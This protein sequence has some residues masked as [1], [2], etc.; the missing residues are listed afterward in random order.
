MNQSWWPQVTAFRGC[1][2]GAGIMS[3]LGNKKVN[4]DIYAMRY[5]RLFG[6][7]ATCQ[8]NRLASWSKKEGDLSYGVPGGSINSGNG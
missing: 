3:I 6:G 4:R 8:D 7:A 2:T 5:E 1:A